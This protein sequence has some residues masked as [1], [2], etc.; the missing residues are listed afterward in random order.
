MSLIAIGLCQRRLR[1][2][3]V[4]FHDWPRRNQC[5]AAEQLERLCSSRPAAPVASP[6]FPA[7]DRSAQKPLVCFVNGVDDEEERVIS[8]DCFEGF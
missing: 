8:G 2:S 7:E 3:G 1:L 6:K 5:L 4:S